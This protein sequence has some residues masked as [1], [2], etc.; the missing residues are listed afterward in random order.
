MDGNEKQNGVKGKLLGGGKR[1][2]KKGGG[3]K[4]ERQISEKLERTKDIVPARR[5]AVR[6]IQRISRKVEEA[7]K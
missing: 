4:A 2:E 7:G 1:G 6:T 3:E 5:E